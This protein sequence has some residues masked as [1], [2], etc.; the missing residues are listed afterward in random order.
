MASPS[1]YASRKSIAGL[2][3][4]AWKNPQDET[5]GKDQ[6]KTTVVRKVKRWMKR[7]GVDGGDVS[8]NGK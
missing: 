6:G 2:A 5:D 4:S 7:N 1:I 8:G 3:L